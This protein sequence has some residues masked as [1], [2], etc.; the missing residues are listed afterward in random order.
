MFIPVEHPVVDGP[1]ASGM[2]PRVKHESV[3]PTFPLGLGEETILA[4]LK[5]WFPPASVILWR[6]RAAKFLV[7]FQ[8]ARTAVFELPADGL[9]KLDARFE[10]RAQPVCEGFPLHILGHRFRQTLET[11][12]SSSG[13]ACWQPRPTPRSP[14]Q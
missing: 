3:E 9:L 6:E 13:P 12:G 7:A 5:K 8:E 1:D 14:G 11:S 4:P 2:S 10:Q